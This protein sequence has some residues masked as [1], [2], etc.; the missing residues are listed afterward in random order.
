MFSWKGEIMSDSPVGTLETIL[1][2][3][4]TEIVRKIVVVFLEHAN[5]VVLSADSG[6]NAIKLA[7]QTDRKID[8]LLSDVQMPGMSGPTLCQILKQSLPNM[9][10]VL[11]T[12]GPDGD[13]LSKQ[14]GWPLIQKPFGPKTLVGMV[15][16]VLRSQDRSQLGDCEFEVA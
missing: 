1:V 8:L 16:T 9:Q 2:V 11:M 5:F 3:E 10:V 13:Q 4:D 6:E 14:Y 7:T 12:G 15:T